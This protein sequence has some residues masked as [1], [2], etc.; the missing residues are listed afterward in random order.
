MD[1]VPDHAAINETVD[2]TKE[3]FG[4]G[5]A[6]FVNSI[7]RSYQRNSRV[8]YPA[9]TAE[10]IATEH[11]YPVELIRQW[12]EIW[13]EEQSELLAISL[14]DP[15]KLHIR[16][17]TLAT[18]ADRL[19]NYFAKRNINCT[20]SAASVNILITD[21]SHAALGDIAFEEG[22]YS[23][24]DTSA[25]LVV[26]LLAPHAGESVLDLFSAPGGK[27]TYAAELMQDTG[28]I[29]AVDKTPHKMKLLKQAAQRLQLS[30]ISM[31]TKDAF[32]YGPVAASF[33]K[34]LVDAPCSGWGVFGKKADLR[35]QLHQDLAAL[36]KLQEK[37]LNYAANF[38]K[39]GG[40][41]VYST[42]TMN[43]A[44]NEQQVLKFLN[45]NKHFSLVKADALINPY[46]TENGFLKTMPL[47]HEM[48]GAFGARLLRCL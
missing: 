11:S 28:E 6:G 30:C 42:C 7:L 19:K 44:E 25:A 34:V 26:E 20:D 47:K 37:A 16:V 17:N 18:S 31:V 45:K 2:L 40:I 41:M 9:E 10:R 33:D 15:A 27:C 12:I 48:D 23:I 39:P 29:V 22:Y 8:D 46:Y 13:G 35:W 36:I 1:S 5:I 3:S 38:V 4:D 43:P 14:N 24:Q 32:S 21:N